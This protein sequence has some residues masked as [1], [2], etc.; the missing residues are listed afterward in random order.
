MAPHMIQ[1]MEILQLN[2]LALQERLDQELEDNPL[3]ENENSDSSSETGES[4]ALDD[5]MG[6]REESTSS[7]DEK[8]LVAG[9][10]ENN[11]SDFERLLEM[12]EEWPDDNV[13]TA[14]RPS[15]NFVSDQ[16]ERQ[17][18]MMA[19]AVDHPAT[20]AEHLTPQLGFYDLPDKVRRFA[21]YLIYNLD[22]DGRLP[23]PLAEIAQ[24]FPEQLTWEEAEAALKVLHQL[25]PPG[26]GARDLKEC[27]LLQVDQDHPD[28]DVLVTLITHH[29][30]DLA[31][32]RIPQ[33]QRKT[34]YSPE[35]I[36]DAL[37]VLK[38]FNPFPGR[39]YQ[40][41]PV[42]R[43]TPDMI[44]E[45]NDKGK[46]EV[47]LLDEYVPSLRVSPKYAK[48]LRNGA[49]RRDSRIHQEKARIRQVAD[50]RDRAAVQ[51]DA[52]S[53][54]DNRRFSDRVSR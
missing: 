6:G 41:R 27:W 51:H 2:A 50:R 28:R 8:E 25:D 11:E 22:D 52:Q 21:E 1:S 20:L 38:T 40:D 39:A 48:M 26:I 24:V 19:N 9:S 31:H 42:Q 12:S 13:I 49:R 29:I 17:D 7:V 37:D 46:Y 10:E 54:P 16:M 15:S 45:K 53:R 32:R 23:A 3:L 43:V 4:V 18:D 35:T 5:D 34:G 33:I 30:D 47:R 14:S 36:K 44:V